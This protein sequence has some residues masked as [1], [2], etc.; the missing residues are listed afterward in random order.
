MPENLQRF[1]I[2]VFGGLNQSDQA[3]TLVRRSY[4]MT[5]G[6]FSQIAPVESPDLLNIDFDSE[7][8]SKRKGSFEDSDITTELVSGDE[9]LAGYWFKVPGSLE[10]PEVLVGKKSIYLNRT[11]TWAQ[12]NNS[13]GNPFTF[14]SDITKCSL[15]YVDNRLFI[16]VDQSNP[17][18]IYESGANLSDPFYSYSTTTTVDSTSA[19]GQKVLN[20]A[21]TT[22]F[23]VGSR[24]IID[25]GNSNEETGYIASIQSGVS[26]TL[27]DNLTNTHNSGKI[28]AVQNLYNI[29]NTSTTKVITG[30]TGTGNYLLENIQNRLIYGSGTIIL[31]Y[32]PVP[33]VASGIWDI[34]NSSTYQASSPI[35]AIT[36]FTPYLT[37]T[38]DQ[39]IYIGTN[40]GW[41]LVT[42]FTASDLVI[43]LDGASPPVNHKSF[44]NT[45]NWLLYLS[46]DK[47]IYGINGT[48]VIDIGRRLKTR[49]F[50]G[51]LDQMSLSSSETS[52]FSF[53]NR[54]RE[55]AYFFFTTDSSYFNDTCVT[56]DFKLGEPPLGQSRQD[57]ERFVR[58][59]KWSI[60]DPGTNDWFVS[61]YRNESSFLGIQKT[62]YTYII[63]TGLNDFGSIGVDTQYYSPIFFAGHEMLSKQ[64]LD[65]YFRA[66]NSG[67]YEV[68]YYVYIDRAEVESLSG[69]F[70]LGSNDS[71]YDTAVY[72]T[73]TYTT[74]QTIR[75]SDDLDFYQ[76]SIQWALLN[77]EPSQTFTI[78]SMG[79]R[80]MSGAEE[81]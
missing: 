16:G 73:G 42:G 57:Y 5:E 53:Y 12:I 72:D 40:S 6:G 29:A 20:V 38:L 77:K 43:R 10:K 23:I 27:E 28:V 3:N 17:I 8:I 1:E 50:D 61:M 60:S 56:V 79:V 11:G 9:L 2:T 25:E 31:N 24:I 7:G 66:I 52:S 36:T 54:E 14:P 63:D 15:T 32:T 58:L 68:F 62:G 35:K 21:S 46:S 19:S 18:Y 59:L 34:L 48:T 55:Q 75:G 65:I 70:N 4:Q 67:D 45:K 51:V 44:C 33:G 71:Q 74:T 22:G 81:R 76:E 39:K 41:E 78:T 69:S 26:I 80:Y 49:S 47:G 30:N 37:N 64:F 13:N